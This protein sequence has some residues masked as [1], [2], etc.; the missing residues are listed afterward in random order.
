MTEY[1]SPKLYSVIGKP[2]AHSLSPALHT[3]AFRHHNIPGILMPWQLETEELAPFVE[4]MRLLDIQG[5]CITIP[6]KED[7]IPLLDGITDR[8]KK[9]GAVNTIYRHDGKLL[10]ENTDVPG[11][12]APLSANPP[13]PDARILI[14]GSG[15]AARSVVVGLQELGLKDI[16]I[17][18]INPPSAERLSAEFN[19]KLIPW[20]ERLDAGADFVI[21]TTPQGM[22]GR[23]VDDNPFPSSGFAGKKGIAY[24]L[25]YIPFKT[26]FL[27]EAEDAGWTTIG[28]LDMF[29]AQAN[30]QFLIWTGK[31]I[32]DI[33]NQLVID[34]LKKRA[35]EG[36]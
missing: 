1:I 28:G 32:P 12:L 21:N 19:L 27:Q 36:M 10:G 14:L 35:E 33:A 7:I 30:Q 3:T 17:T 34:I 29:L 26:R 22:K 23:Y 2:I 11:F 18:N 25:I 6:H 24:D 9:V 8:A 16:S 15:G 20:A 4:A 13:R 5:S 31:H